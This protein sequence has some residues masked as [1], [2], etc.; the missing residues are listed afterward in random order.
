LTGEPKLER[1]IG[2]GGGI[3]LAFNGVLGSAIFA[4]PALLA[5]DYGT[6]SPWLFPVVAIG[7]LLIILP[8]ARSASAFDR[9][10]G[11]ALYGAVFGRFAG[12]Q[13]G[14]VY[15]VARAA[16]FAGNAMSS[17]PIWRDGGP[18]PTRAWREPPSSSAFPRSSP[19]STSQ[20]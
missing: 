12:F 2:L 1:K 4:L 6:F 20:A 8:F 15:Y 18:E 5:A 19:S 10:G 7:S 9:N 11:P 3:L 16:A 14:W 13:L 17:P